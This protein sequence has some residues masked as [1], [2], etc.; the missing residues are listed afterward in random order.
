M[1]P[2]VCL[3]PTYNGHRALV[4]E[5]TA[6]LADAGIRAPPDKP[7]SELTASALVLES[8]AVMF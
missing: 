3:A 7:D 2:S 6:V 8:R 1:P 4:V 5:G